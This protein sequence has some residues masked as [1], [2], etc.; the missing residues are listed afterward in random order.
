MDIVEYRAEINL[1]VE[2]MQ[3][4]L[5]LKNSMRNIYIALYIAGKPMMSSEVA[6]LVGHERAYVNMRLQQLV[7]LGDYARVEQKGKAKYF[8][9]IK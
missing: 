8:E 1:P 5:K 4:A 9:A 7:D 2:V 6:H 3:K